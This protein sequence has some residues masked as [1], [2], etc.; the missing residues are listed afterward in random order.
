MRRYVLILML[1]GGGLA[2]TGQSAEAQYRYRA[3]YRY[4][5]VY[6]SRYAPNYGY[7]TP[8][9]PAYG[10]GYAQTYPVAPSYAYPVMGAGYTN[11]G[12]A[13][14]VRSLYLHY[15]QREPEP[16]GMQAWL[17]RLSQIGGDVNRLTQEFARAAVTEQNTNNPAYRFQ[18]YP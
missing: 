1:A 11:T 7:T 13:D 4:G 16:E 10:Y 5:P 3:S 9:Y 17:I 15:L 18:S 6:G 12:G 2:F 8:S 14:F